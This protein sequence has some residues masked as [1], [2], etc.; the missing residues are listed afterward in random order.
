VIWETHS[1]ALDLENNLRDVRITLAYL[2]MFDENVSKAYKILKM[3]FMKVSCT[4]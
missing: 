2:Y 4:V 3:N 1:S